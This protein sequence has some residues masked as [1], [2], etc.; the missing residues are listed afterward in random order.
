LR[1][2]LIFVVVSASAVAQSI[3]TTYAGAPYVFDGDGK[4]AVSAPLGEVAAV[5]VDAHGTVYVADPS[6][7]MVMKFDPNGILT[8]VAGNGTPGNSGDS[9]PAASAALNQPRGLAI[10]AAGDLFI[11]DSASSVIRRVAPGGVITT[12]AGTGKSG[13]SGDG[14]PAAGAQLNAPESLA[15]DS[16]GNLYTADSGNHRIRKISTN[17]IITTVAGDGTPAAGAS[18]NTPRGVAADQA[19]AIYISDTKNNRIRKLSVDGTIATI[20]GNGARGYSGDGVATAMSLAAPLGITVDAAGVVYFADSMN[21]RVRKISP[22]G[23]LSTLAG[24]DNQAYTGDGGPAAAAFLDTPGSVAVDAAGNVFIA[25]TGNNRVRRISPTNFIST[26]AGSGGF[27]A[28]G[29][30]GPALAASFRAPVTIAIDAAG[31]VYVADQES[32]RVRKITASN[33]IGTA[34]GSGAAGSY[35]DGGPAASAALYNPYGISLDGAGNLYIAEFA[36]GRIRKVTPGGAIATIAGGGSLRQ[37]GALA[38]NSILDS[39]TAA[40]FD[41]AG[42]LYI[43]EF[44][45]GRVRKV[46]TSGVITTFASGLN[47]PVS[48]AFDAAGNL[49]VAEKDRV[50]RISPGGAITPFAG[51]GQLR[52]SGDGGPAAAASVNGPRGLIFDRAGNLLFADYNNNRVRQV[53]PNG[54]ITTVA[55]NGLQ[56]PDGN[57]GPPTAA[58]IDRPS[59]LAFDADGNLYITEIGQRRVRRVL[60]SA[61]SFGVSSAALTFSAKSGGALPPPQN[62]NLSTPLAGPAFQV[63]VST[64]DGGGWLAASTLG[65]P[66]PAAIQIFAGQTGLPPG[67]YQGTVTIRVPLANP[68]SRIIS[69]GFTVDRTEPARLGADPDRLGFSFVTGAALAT[70]QIQISNQG[71]GSLD[72][73]AAA[74]VTASAASWLSVAPAAGTATSTAP[75]LLTVTADSAKLAPGVYTGV[76]AITSSTGQS[77]NIVVTATVNSGPQ[78]ILLSQTGLTFTAVVG[79]GTPPPQ[80]FGVLNTGQGQMNWSVFASTLSGGSRWLTVTPDSGATNASSLSVPLVEVGVNPVGLAPGDYYGQI[81][82]TAAGASNTPQ[83]VT[84]VL[85][86]LPAGSDPGPLIRPTGLVFTSL[87]GGANTGAQTVLVSNVTGTPLSFISGRLS[88]SPGNLFTH[89]PAD[90]VAAPDQPARIAVQ[91]ALPALIAPGIYRGTLTLQFSS[92]AARTVSLLFVTV[93]GAAAGAQ[94]G[95]VVYPRASAQCM[96]TRLFPVFTS[97]GYDFDVAAG[98]PVSLET[99]VVDDCGVP[100]GAGSVVATFSNG[101]PPLGLASLKDGRWTA[102]WLARNQSAAR[103]T[104]S[105]SAGIPGTSVKG[106]AQIGGSLRSNPNPPLVSAGAVV[107][108]ASLAREFPLAPGGL[109]SIFGSKLA[110]DSGSAST[111]PLPDQLA[112]TAVTIGARSLSLLDVSQDRISAQLPYDLPVNARY[113]L[114]VQRGATISP[115]EEVTVA[116]AQP[117]IF[118]KDN[119]GS[120]QGLIY[121]VASDGSQSLAEPGNGAGAGDS[122]LIQ[123]AGLGSVNPPVLAGTAAP[124]DPLAATV[125]TVTL[126]IGGVDAPV[127]FAGLAPAM[128]GVYQVRALVP[129]GITSGDAVPV[130]LTIAGRSS[131]PVNVT[132]R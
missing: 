127:S 86:L 40:V 114:L 75:A 108:S 20:A 74:A 36:T 50:R 1:N 17:G 115:P 69:V 73:T 22:S 58:A 110:D 39:P 9:G 10:G 12:I 97:L 59:G 15:L 121:R 21:S 98:W 128:T 29:D 96:P 53:S 120:G 64:S 104:I 119:S 62:I 90:A 54:I 4:R 16:A 42:A 41:A 14:A 67:S 49:Y 3:I 44:D 111:L 55:G 112:G 81:Q 35:G 132:V 23:V 83:T 91:P 124:F 47:G 43:A 30:G 52:Y 92:G 107:S 126:T 113:P 61:P 106:T 79:G 6:N 8:V 68:P 46:S 37:D 27:G 125:N 26:A 82:V 2:I 7:H 63:S 11:A 5:A 13:Y 95:R 34:V 105:V 99:L 24:G 72:F 130:V 103:V 31:A 89:L 122:I 80:T 102:S 70:R 71:G 100:L 87:A 28:S 129:A 51:N 131:P 84:V 117:A 45:G 85:N 57:G 66:L 65:G 118:T 93:S 25:D 32:N 123:C 78:T 76:I 94:A 18:L 48:L 109:I 38:I 88:D 19:G 101:D 77:Q 33:V 60:S 116:A 56:E